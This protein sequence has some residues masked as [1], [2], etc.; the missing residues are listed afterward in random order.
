[1]GSRHKNKG[2]GP[3]DESVPVKTLLLRVAEVLDPMSLGQYVM[4]SHVK[5]F[6]YL[7]LHLHFVI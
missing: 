4:I 1:M 3:E 6:H 7:F 5:S 2:R